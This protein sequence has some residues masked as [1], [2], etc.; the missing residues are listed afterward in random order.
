MK[1]IDPHI[2]M[3][4][5]TTDEY[6]ALAIHGVHTIAEPAFWAGFDRAPQGFRDYFGQLTV[7]EPGRAA[8]FG[9]K[10]YCWIGMNPKESEN[11]ELA[12]EVIRMMPEFLDRPTV[13]GIGEIGLNKNS[14]NELK[15]LEKQVALAAERNDLLFLHTPHLEDKL[16]GTRLIMDMISNESR[17]NPSR[18]ILVHVESHTIKEI[19]DRGFWFGVT[20]YPWVKCSPAM[21]VDIVEIYGSDKMWIDSGADWGVS[22]PLS[23]LKTANEMRMRGHSEPLIQKIFFDNPNEFLS[24]CPKFKAQ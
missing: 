9:I 15:S 16:K 14:R 20:L 21:G 2:H 18:V 8:K 5:R 3:I 23:T 11:L 4:N 7:F 10:H 24:Q 1:I 13:L 6:Q 19:K 22:D 12:D 17:I